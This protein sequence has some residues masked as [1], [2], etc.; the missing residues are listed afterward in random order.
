[1]D[2]MDNLNCD[3]DEI[4]QEFNKNRNIIREKD[5][6]KIYPGVQD[7]TIWNSF[8]YSY[9]LP[10]TQTVSDTDNSRVSHDWRTSTD[11]NFMMMRACDAPIP[12]GLN[13]PI[14]NNLKIFD[15]SDGYG[16]HE[17]IFISTNDDTNLDWHVKSELALIENFVGVSQDGNEPL[18]KYKYR[19]IIWKTKTI[20]NKN[21]NIQGGQDVYIHM[22][23]CVPLYKNSSLGLMPFI[24]STFLDNFKESN[25]NIFINKYISKCIAINKCSIKFIKELQERYDWFDNLWPDLQQDLSNACTPDENFVTD[26]PTE[27]P[28]PCINP[29]QW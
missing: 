3:P 4:P 8:G 6:T 24:D 29:T 15:D 1:M 5:T 26:I 13:L 11:N 18:I 21:F 10:E 16:Y 22:I 7:D 17:P 23:E 9:S 2:F 12:G 19:Y 14:C 28:Q 27:D 20:T 25:A